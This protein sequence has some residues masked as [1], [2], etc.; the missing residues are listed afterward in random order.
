M[1]HVLR[2]WLVLHDLTDPQGKPFLLYVGPDT[3]G[4]MTE[5]GINARGDIVHAMPARTRYLPRA[6]RTRR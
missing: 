5:V 3:A 4:R 6:K 2:V 1:E